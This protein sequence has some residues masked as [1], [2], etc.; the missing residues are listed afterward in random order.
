MIAYIKQRTKN[1]PFFT[2]FLCAATLFCFAAS[3]HFFAHGMIRNAFL[4]IACGLLI[5]P[6]LPLAEYWLCLRF[7]PVFTF[8][9]VLLFTGG[10]VLG[11]GFDFYF[12]IPCWDDILH[13]ASGVIFACLGYAIADGMIAKDIKY[14]RFLCFA[15][16][17]AFSLAI[18]LLWEMFEYAGTTFLGMDMEED[19][20]INHIRSFLLAGSH[21]DIVEID[22]ITQTIIIYGNGQQYVIEGGYLDIGLY[23]TLN[24]ML[25]C[26]VGA[27]LLPV[28]CAIGRLFGNHPE[29]FFIPHLVNR[30]A[31]DV[32][33]DDDN[34]L[35]DDSNVPFQK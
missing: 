4:A 34:T 21:N 11:P 31:T 16:A 2:V 12:K 6:G 32:S 5:F 25:V 29:S 28:L 33:L 15:T 8:L 7:A 10:L 27:I 3:G 35:P 24:D 13:T 19:T 17:V 26:L 22:Q 1:D 14:R 9:L 18:A 23:D 30:P 20:I